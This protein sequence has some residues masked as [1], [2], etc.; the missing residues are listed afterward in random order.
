MF[1]LRF[2]LPLTPSCQF[3]LCHAVSLVSVMLSDLAGS[4]FN[5]NNAVSKM[6]GFEAILFDSIETDSIE[7]YFLEST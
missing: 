6:I 5:V 3:N 1:L 2:C 7:S 4:A